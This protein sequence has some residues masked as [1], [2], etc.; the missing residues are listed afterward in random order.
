MLLL[1]QQPPIRDGVEHVFDFRD[2]KRFVI[3]FYPNGI[4]IQIRSAHIE[5]KTTNSTPIAAAAA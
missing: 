4:C 1:F 3:A 5:P 2:G